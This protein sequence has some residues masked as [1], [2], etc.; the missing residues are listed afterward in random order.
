M[1]GPNGE[2][3]SWLDEGSFPRRKE[4]SMLDG[5]SFLVGEKVQK[6]DKVY[7]EREEEEERG[8]GG[9]GDPSPPPRG[10]GQF[11]VVSM[12]GSLEF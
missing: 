11:L 4:A 9:G 1:P 8:G 6:N 5:G 7:K 10:L 12:V 3:A 2:E